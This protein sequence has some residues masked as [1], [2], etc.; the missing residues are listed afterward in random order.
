MLTVILIMIPVL[1]V[2]LITI[3]LCKASARSDEMNEAIMNKTVWVSA[4]CGE[5]TRS[6]DDEVCDQCGRPSEMILEEDY[7]VVE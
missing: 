3:A 7:E 5:P 1:L 6:P 2:Y 4:C